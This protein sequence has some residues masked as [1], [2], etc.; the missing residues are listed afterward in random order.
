MAALLNVASGDVSFA[1]T[2]ADVIALVQSA[3]ASGDFGTAKDTL[4]DENQSSCPLTLSAVESGSMT[5]TIE[6]PALG[7]G[8]LGSSV[9]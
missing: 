1:F 2:E 9:R 7:P 6:R 3:W 5:R 4:A 8:A